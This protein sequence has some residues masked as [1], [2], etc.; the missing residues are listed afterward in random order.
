MAPA[1]ERRTEKHRTRFSHRAHIIYPLYIIFSFL[2]LYKENRFVLVFQMAAKMLIRH[3][4]RG[5]ETKVQN[6]ALDEQGHMAPKNL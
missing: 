3:S 6:A 1:R 4:F 5:N 2:F